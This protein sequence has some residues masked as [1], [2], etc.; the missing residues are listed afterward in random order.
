VIFRS[1]SFEIISENLTDA[2]DCHHSQ[3]QLKLTPCRAKEQA[4][5]A[6]NERSRTIP[7]LKQVGFTTFFCKSR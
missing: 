7:P 2:Q 4:A 1:G 3:E 6:C 5:Y